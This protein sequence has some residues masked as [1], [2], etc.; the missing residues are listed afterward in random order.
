MGVGAAGIEGDR[1]VDRIPAMNGRI[2][3]RAAAAGRAA[4]AER[5]RVFGSWA[6]G[7][8]GEES[9]LD[10]ALVVPDPVN[11]RNAL[12]AAIIATAKREVA[13]DLVVLA[14]STWVQGRTLL[15]RQIRA[16]GVLVYGN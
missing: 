15:A 11:R 8:A 6:R 3:E 4:G 14:H 1:K 16:E 7:D 9:D 13:L 5:V 12:R 2:L 10:L